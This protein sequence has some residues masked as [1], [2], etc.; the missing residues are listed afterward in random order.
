MVTMGPQKTYHVLEVF[1]GA[2]IFPWENWGVQGMYG[3][4]AWKSSQCGDGNSSKT[5]DSM[6]IPS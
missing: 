6:A 2:F 1:Y 3:I 5:A 4:F